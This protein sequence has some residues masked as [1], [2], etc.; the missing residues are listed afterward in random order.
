MVIEISSDYGKYKLSGFSG[1]EFPKSPVIESPTSI[2]F[3]AHTIQRAIGIIFATGNDDLRPVMS[4]IFV[5]LSENDV[6]FAATD[7]HK[8]V[9]YKRTDVKTPP[10]FFYYPK[11]PMNF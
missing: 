3:E 6:T 10:I 11:K 1:D 8:L 5:Q 9:R 2:Q 4:G 7:A